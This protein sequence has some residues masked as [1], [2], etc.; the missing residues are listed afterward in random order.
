MLKNKKSATGFTIVELLIV[1]VVIGILAAITI[2]AFNGIQN[3]GYNSAVQSD[4]RSLATYIER[5]KVLNGEVYPSTLAVAD[6]KVSRNAYSRGY[7]N[8]TSWFN[9]LYCRN[10]IDPNAGYALIAESKSGD[11]FQYSTYSGGLS[12]ASF[13]IRAS[14]TTCVDA[15][16]PTI[17]PGGT[18]VQW[19]YA[20]DGWVAGMGV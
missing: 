9:L 2:V 13:P 11:V 17:T 8:G 15:G 5:Q 16:T 6:V 20:N 1:I 3:R 7:N 18:V 14:A 12:K 19:L 4:L 10:S